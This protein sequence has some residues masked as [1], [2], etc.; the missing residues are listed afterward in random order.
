MN[1][2]RARIIPVPADGLCM[3]HCVHAAEDPDWMKNRHISGMSLE[4]YTEIEDVEWAQALRKQFISYLVGKGIHEAAERV[5]TAGSNEYLTTDEMPHLAEMLRGKIEFVD[6]EEH[7][8]PM[9]TY[10]E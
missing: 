1:I 5:A 9:T 4:K 10:G 7:E 2:Y 8:C 3:Y 6:L